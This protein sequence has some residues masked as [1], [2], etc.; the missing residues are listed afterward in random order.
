MS[1]IYW[2]PIQEN[3]ELG[4]ANTTAAV[5]DVLDAV[6]ANVINM[7]F[8]FKPGFKIGL[9]GSFSHDNWDTLL[10]YTWFHN[11]NS[12]SSDGPSGGNIIPMIGAPASTGDSLYSSV[13]E[14][15]RLKMDIIDLD[16][17]RWYYVGTN[18][19]FRPSFGVRA[20]W[21][22][23][24]LVFNGVSATDEGEVYSKS[25]SWAIG[26]MAALDSSW[27]IGCGFRIFGNA[28]T[29]L[30]FTKYTRLRYNETHTNVD[31]IPISVK[32]SHVYAIRPHFDLELGL[33]WGTYL[34]CNNWYLD[35]KAGYEM[36]AFLFQNMFRH[37]SSATMAGNSA[38]PYGNLYIQGLTATASVD[39]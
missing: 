23:Q 34:D 16:L 24:R 33:G 20:D 15:W 12:Q 1:F 21:I 8:K 25:S 35:F 22:R 38:S 13:S 18:L 32:Q 39:F 4:L 5:R 6:T 29:D 37:F 28:E 2:Q 14:N 17:G 11:T 30:L 3:M 10:E 7:N 36:Q 26:P 9:G 31:L 19:M 27:N